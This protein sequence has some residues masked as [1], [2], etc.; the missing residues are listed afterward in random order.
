MKQT[1]L[2]V[3]QVVTGI[4]SILSLTLALLPVAGYNL[5]RLSIPLTSYTTLG[6]T[7]I[8]YIPINLSYLFLV[9][10]ILFMILTLILIFR[11]GKKG[12]PPPLKIS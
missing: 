10:S 7:V 2:T 4:A 1:Y 5:P 12:I 3:F 6:E 11:A 9:L 8:R